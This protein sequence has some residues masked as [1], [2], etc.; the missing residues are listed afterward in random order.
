MLIDFFEIIWKPQNLQRPL[1]EP[2]VRDAERLVY[3]RGFLKGSPLFL[4]SLQKE[5]WH[6]YP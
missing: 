1:Q 3:Y 6:A 2:E 4:L 5:V